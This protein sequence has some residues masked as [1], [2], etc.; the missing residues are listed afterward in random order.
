MV[1]R[2]DVTEPAEA[3]I[4]EIATYIAARSPQAADR[5]LTGI[6]R[7][8]RS[9]AIMPNRCSKAPESDSFGT[10]LRQLMCGKSR[11]VYRIVFR[12]VDPERVEIIAVR[13]GARDV[14][15]PEQ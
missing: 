9:L 11:N 10:E 6:S 2:V 5:W 12:V 15:R 8:I 3:E 7:S 4:L 1:Y 13:H 14:M